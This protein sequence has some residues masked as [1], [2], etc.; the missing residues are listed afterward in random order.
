MGLS[1]SQPV[2]SP[3][4]LVLPLSSSLAKLPLALFVLSKGS[5]EG[6]DLD[7]GGGPFGTPGSL[8]LILISETAD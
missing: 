4:F 6:F 7:S 8:S 1:S 2:S 3:L 5:V